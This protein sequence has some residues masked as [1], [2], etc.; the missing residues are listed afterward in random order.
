MTIFVIKSLTH[1][2]MC[3]HEHEHTNTHANSSL[4]LHIFKSKWWIKCTYTLLKI[5]WSSIVINLHS[6]V[7]ALYWHFDNL[8]HLYTLGNMSEIIINIL[9]K[10]LPYSLLSFSFLEGILFLFFFLYSSIITTKEKQL[11]QINNTKYKTRDNL[12]FYIS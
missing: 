4:S 11:F 8:S 9:W 5:N 3:P 2:H 12:F 10:N 6:C 7:K 1:M